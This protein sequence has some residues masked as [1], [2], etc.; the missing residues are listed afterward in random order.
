MHLLLET[1]SPVEVTKN[2]YHPQRFDAAKPTPSGV[3]ESPEDLKDKLK[4]MGYSTQPA[5]HEARRCTQPQREK[6]RRTWNMRCSELTQVP[7]I[8]DL[9]NANPKTVRCST[10]LQQQLLSLQQL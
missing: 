4:P 7:S 6:S 10:Q 1:M 9:G 8:P 5:E 2:R 3:L